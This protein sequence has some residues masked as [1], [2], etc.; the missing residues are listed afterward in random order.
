MTEEIFP[1]NQVQYFEEVLGDYEWDHSASEKLMLSFKDEKLISTFMSDLKKENDEVVYF[2]PPK[3][4]V[5]VVLNFVNTKCNACIKLSSS[6]SDHLSLVE[7]L[8]FELANT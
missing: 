5:Q 6:D 8:I 4:F 1:G 2:E 7:E 3:W